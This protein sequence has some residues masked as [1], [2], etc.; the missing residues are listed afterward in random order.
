MIQR[1]VNINVL[2]EV[3]TW[4]MRLNYYIYVYI[5]IYLYLDDR[6]KWGERRLI[7]RGLMDN[8]ENNTAFGPIEL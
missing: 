3:N 5:Y 6:N 8:M 2:L 1:R 7:K 4:V